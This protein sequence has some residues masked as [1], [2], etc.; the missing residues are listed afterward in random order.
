MT[1]TMRKLGRTALAGVAVAGLS[2]ATTALASAVG[3]DQPGAPTE[4]TLTIHKYAGSPT[5]APND[6]TELDPADFSDRDLLGGVEFTATRVGAWTDNAGTL[7]C[8]AIDLTD[9]AGWDAAESVLGAGAAGEIVDQALAVAGDLCATSDVYVDTTGDGST[10]P[11][12]LLTWTLPVG[13]YH[14]EETDPGENN[15]VQEATPFFVTIPLPTVTGEGDAAVYDWNYN[16]HVYPKNQ[17]IQ[18]PQ[19]VISDRP[20]DL[21]T[22]SEVTWT[23][24]GTVPSLNGEDVAFTDAV[25]RDKLNDRLTYSSS[26]VTVGGVVVYSDVDDT[27]V[28]VAD[29]VALSTDVDDD[30]ALW[31]LTAP[32]GLDFLLAN[33]GA[34]IVITLNT[35]V[36]G[37]G[38]ITNGGDGVNNPADFTFNETTVPTT[39]PYT[40][41][42]QLA[43]LKVDESNPATVLA[44]A[45]FAVVELPAG[46]DECVA[47]LGE[48]ETVATGDSDENGVV[49]WFD[50][51]DSPLGSP[52]NLWVANSDTQLDNPTKDYCVYETQAPAGYT[53][54]DVQQ[55]TI[56]AGDLTEASDLVWENPQKDGPGL[57][58]TGGAGTILMS[59]GGL[60]L[61]GLGVGTVLLARKRNH[62]VA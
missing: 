28:D 34:E 40:Y 15:I 5:G 4:G 17:I 45:E 20:A 13:L 54:T 12:G 62:A 32:A 46:T 60:A 22:G 26:T 10:E 59:L 2:F 7:E 6:G 49:Q 8:V 37:V 56:N 27:T 52:L 51:G 39:M 25:L 53:A 21:V 36:T 47:D 31:T 48:Q 19:K 50:S 55:V 38:E 35:Q 30:H 42:G 11:L 9:P 43:I 33:Q 16:V 23:I 14:V 41:W 3:P 29:I 57:P 24:T 61:V 1:N 44:N 58:V 18:Q